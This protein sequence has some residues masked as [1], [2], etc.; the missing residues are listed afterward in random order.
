MSE[1]SFIICIKPNLY[2]K[3]RSNKVLKND[4]RG[5]KERNC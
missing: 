5:E 4:M 2:N 1:N 3:T